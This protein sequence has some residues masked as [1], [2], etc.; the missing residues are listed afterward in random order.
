MLVRLEMPRGEVHEPSGWHNY[1]CL[2]LKQI[3]L[4][5]AHHDIVLDAGQ[6]MQ[7]VR[8]EK[9]IKDILVQS[10]ERSLMAPRNLAKIDGPC[11]IVPAPQSDT[12]N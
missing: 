7:S 2:C 10:A 11:A 5:H 8:P 12:Q 1:D 6:C 3:L 9:S 4:S